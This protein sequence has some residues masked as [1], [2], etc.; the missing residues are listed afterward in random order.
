MLYNSTQDTRQIF[1]QVWDKM[2]G[3]LA[4]EPLEQLIS[5]IIQQHPEYH[6]FLK[7]QESSLERKFL[8]EMG[9]TNPF[10]HMGMHIAIQEQI[11]TNQPVGIREAY[12]EMLIKLKD[13]H[14]VEHNIIECLGNMMWQAQQNQKQ[15]DFKQYISCIKKQLRAKK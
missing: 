4:L 14:E 12:Q 2:Q 6:D 7:N 15:P 9:E 11:Q 10:L 5:E 1:F 3:Q 8:P 13:P